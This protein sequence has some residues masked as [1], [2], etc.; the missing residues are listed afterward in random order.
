MGHCVVVPAQPVGPE[1][2]GYENHLHLSQARPPDRTL[3]QEPLQSVDYPLQQ[4][5]RCSPARV[6][7]GSSRTQ[8]PSPVS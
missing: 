2:P 5:P 7:L 6:A 3:P 8:G 1:E 4:P